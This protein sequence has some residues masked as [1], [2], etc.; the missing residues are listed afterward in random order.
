MTSNER[1]HVLQNI[2]RA[3]GLAGAVLFHSRDTFYY[4]GTAQP[5]WLAVLPDDYTLFVRR[6]YE[7]ALGESWLEPS[8]I[9]SAKNLDAVVKT[10]FPGPNPGEVI[11]TEL[12]LLTIPQARALNRALRGRTLRDISPDVLNQRMIKGEDEVQSIRKAALAVHAGHLAVGSVLRPGISELELAAAVEHAQRI[13]G[14]E[15]CFFL[16]T[17]DFVMSRGPLASG[18]NLRQTSG[19][20]FTLSGAGLSSAVPTGASR[21]IVR[22]GDFV[23]VDVPACVEG[24]HADQSRTYVVGKA[25]VKAIDLFGRLREIADQVIRLIHPGR[26]CKELFDQAVLLADNLGLSDS[27]MRFD[28]GGKAHF[29]GHGIGLEINEPPLISAASKVILTPGMTVALELHI[30][31]PYGFT[32]KLEDTIHITETGAELLTLSPRELM[33]N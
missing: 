10:M 3:T 13:A 1:I 27:F 26:S 8:R 23:L 17:I 12:D 24:Y 4:T 20:L 22:E 29:I 33:E 32:M 9:R 5:S 21:R 15:G 2:L 16:R 30:M 7:I 25:P 19:T 28:D 18:P 6:G 14:H 11:G 31:E